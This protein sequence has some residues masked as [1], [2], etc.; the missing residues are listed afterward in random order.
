VADSTTPRE[1]FK[2]AAEAAVRKHQRNII[3]R[4]LS[5]AD[6]AM[7]VGLSRHD[8]G[9]LDVLADAAEAAYGDAKP[10]GARGQRAV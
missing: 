4:G 9:L 7:H 5:G 2:E 3:D 10:L 6:S 8:P 1:R